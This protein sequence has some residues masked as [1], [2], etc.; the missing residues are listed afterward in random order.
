MQA[1][2]P[3]VAHP[4]L[5]AGVLTCQGEIQERQ[6]NNVDALV[7]YDQAVSTAKSSPDDEMLASALYSRGYVRGLQGRFAE[8][9]EDHRQ[10]QQLYEKLA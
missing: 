10:S 7:L 1:L 9:L 4:G 6:G 8:A 5:R 3:R 2:L